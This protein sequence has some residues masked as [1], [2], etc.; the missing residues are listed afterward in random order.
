MSEDIEKGLFYDWLATR[1]EVIQEM[2]NKYPPWVEYKMN[3][4]PCELYSYS[5]DG[6]VTVLTT[7]IFGLV[8][9]KVFGVNPEELIVEK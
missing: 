1:P 2:G 4:K 8:P 6:T 3:G 5:E 7:D 9:Y